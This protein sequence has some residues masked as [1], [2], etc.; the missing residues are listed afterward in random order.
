MELADAS[1]M[2][3]SMLVWNALC[4]VLGVFREMPVYGTHLNCC[5]V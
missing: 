4:D 5:C 1:Y 3:P 2:L